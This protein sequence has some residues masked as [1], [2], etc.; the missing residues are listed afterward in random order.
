MRNRDRAQKNQR[1][2]FGFYLCILYYFQ[3]FKLCALENVIRKFNEIFFLSDQMGVE[4]DVPDEERC[5]NNVWTECMFMFKLPI[6]F[7]P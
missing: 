6:L 2:R 5:N 1:K 4:F 7:I 3:V